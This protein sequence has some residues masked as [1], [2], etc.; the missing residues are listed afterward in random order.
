MKQMAVTDPT[1]KKRRHEVNNS[2]AKKV[3]QQQTKPFPLHMVGYMVLMYSIQEQIL[4]N[5]WTGPNLFEV[6]SPEWCQVKN[7]AIST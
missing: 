5:S 4:N 2:N 6:I 7:Q 3:L 1:Y